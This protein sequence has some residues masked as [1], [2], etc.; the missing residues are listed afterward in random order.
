M[1]F[2]YW[3]LSLHQRSALHMAAEGGHKETLD[4][5]VDV[6][7]ADINITDEDGV[8]MISIDGRLV[9]LI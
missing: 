5:L 9:L 1:Y 7:G 6:A 2:S 3:F 8:C 4:Y